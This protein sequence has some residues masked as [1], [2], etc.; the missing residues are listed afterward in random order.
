MLALWPCMPL[1]QELV[2]QGGEN[3]TEPEFYLSNGRY[4]MESWEHDQGMVLVRNDQYQGEQPG[5]TRI[6]YTIF[7]DPMEQALNAFQTGDVDLAPVSVANADFVSGDSELSQLRIQTPVSG[8]WQLRLDM[9]NAA[10]V[11]ADV[12]VRKALY[13][14]VDRDLLTQ[15]V[16]KGFNTTAYV[17]MPPDIPGNDP[18]AR[19]QGTI[20]DAKQFLADAGYPNGE[21]FPGFQLGHS[22]T[23]ENA[24][25][26]CEALLQMWKENLGI[27]ATTFPVP[28]DW[29]QRI[30]TEAYD[31]YLGQW[32]TDFPDAYEWHNVVF[33]GDAWQSK[34]N[35]PTYLDMIERANVEPDPAT[36]ISLY[37]EA[38]RYLIQEVMATIPLFFSGRVSVIQPWV[39]NLKISPYD[40]PVLN[41]DGVV[42]E[43]H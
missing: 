3:W 41:I 22:A 2:E 5:I 37:A 28:T 9:S 29:R 11:I 10:S 30:R 24:Q 13:L 31:M 40:G 20:D 27:D 14:G 7:Q 16:L 38:E 35:D 6:E 21:G 43:D 32:V 23:Q 39:K 4:K 34:W 12:N 25:L 15:N 26:V 18:N 1:K 17:L 36:R 33:E 8:N 42:I 19:L